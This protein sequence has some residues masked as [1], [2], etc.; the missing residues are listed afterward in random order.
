MTLPSI[1]A[2][3]ESLQQLPLCESYSL[4]QLESL[5]L[6]SERGSG[7]CVAQWALGTLRSGEREVLGLW[8]RAAVD[9]P[10]VF[11]NLRDRGVNEIR[12]VVSTDPTLVCVARLHAIVVPSATSI[13]QDSQVGSRYGHRF[14]RS[15]LAACDTGSRMRERLGRC[16]AQIDEGFSQRAGVAHISR[17]LRWWET[18]RVLRPSRAA[19]ARLTVTPALDPS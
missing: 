15:L 1:D 3:L 14:Q 8:L 7:C 9:W 16:A 13:W 12:H 18:D 4:A 11:E 6:G 19:E 17:Q 10:I 2:C 5:P